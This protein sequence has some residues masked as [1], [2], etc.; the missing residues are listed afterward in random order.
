M[1]W[2]LWSPS[3]VPNADQEHVKKNRRENQLGV[4]NEYQEKNVNQNRSDRILP[5]T[6]LTEPFSNCDKTTE[7]SHDSREIRFTS[8][9]TPLVR[10]DIQHILHNLFP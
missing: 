9:H 10:T 8:S 3:V 6:Y 2:V 5:I 4:Q 7:N 1:G